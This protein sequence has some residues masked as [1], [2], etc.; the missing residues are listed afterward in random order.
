MCLICLKHKSQ[1]ALEPSANQFCK[2]TGA[3][4]AEALLEDDKAL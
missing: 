2:H 3:I 1:G 4:I